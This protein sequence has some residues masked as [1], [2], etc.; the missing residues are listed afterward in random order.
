MGR[1]LKIAIVAVAAVLLVGGV[2]C[3]SYRHCQWRE[4]DQSVLVESDYSLAFIEMDD[5]G[6]MWNK[7]QVE[8]AM[9]LIRSKADERNTIVLTFVHGWHHSAEC[10]D[11]NVEGFRQALKQLSAN[12]NTSRDFNV[13]GLYIGWRGRSLPGFL[14]YGTFWGRK[15]AAERIGEN[16]M[17]EFVA[18]L[19]ELYVEYRPDA[20][21]PRSRSA[22]ADEAPS[23]NGAKHFLGMVIIG[24]SF[25]SQVLLKAISAPLEDQFQRV[26]PAPAYLR[27]AQP[28]TP[29]PER[30]VTVSGIGDLV[31]LINPA[32]EASQYHRLDILSRGLSYSRLQNPIIL[33]VSAENDTARHRLFTWGRIAGEFFGGKPRKKNDVERNVERQALGVYPGHV[34]HQLIPTDS[35]V[36]LKSRTMRGDPRLCN[37]RETC[38]SDWYEWATKAVPSKPDSINQNEPA[39][40]KVRSFDFSCEVVFNNVELSRLDSPT[41]AGATNRTQAGCRTPI[42]YQ[43]FIV[44]RTSKHIIDNHSGIFTQPFLDFLVPYIRYIE[45]KS[46]VNVSDK[47]RTREQEMQ[48][49]EEQRPGVA[50]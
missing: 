20:R 16:D 27:D 46:L 34:T 48:A 23:D 8:G 45:I 6:W 15:G 2:G 29:N 47:K 31:V 25:G 12:L 50:R 21:R 43:P 7:N 10:C 41:P 18:R 24:H 32:V 13:V 44:A 22:P 28:G 1:K 42:P 19:Q 17:K 36:K 4:G 11:G 26:N 40:A 49:I 35:N 39:G 5:E 14:D 33:T 3:S 38:E 30:K 9:R 37:N